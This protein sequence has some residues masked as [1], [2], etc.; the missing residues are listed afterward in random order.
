MVS[1]LWPA[2]GPVFGLL[3]LVYGAHP[4]LPTPHP[5]PVAPLQKLT[6]TSRF[7]EAIKLINT[8]SPSKFP[9]LLRR[10]IAKLSDAKVLAHCALLGKDMGMVQG[11][12]GD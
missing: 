1:A 5:P 7:C 3:A 4:T 11:R 12:A 8:V 10:I 2:E 9:L 6:L